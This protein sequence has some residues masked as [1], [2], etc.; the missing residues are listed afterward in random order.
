MKICKWF[1]VCPMKMFYERGQLDKKF[2][3]FYCKD[4]WNT[5]IRYEKEEKG[6]YH[7]D[8][9]RPDGII[10]EHLF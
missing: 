9:M 8:N 6:I 3:D 10:D 1:Q 7:P 2:I 5:C 4:N